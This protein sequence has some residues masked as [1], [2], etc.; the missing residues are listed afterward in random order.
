MFLYLDLTSGLCRAVLPMFLVS[1]IAYRLASLLIM[2]MCLNSCS[3]K[4]KF[5]GPL[6]QLVIMLFT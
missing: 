3:E 5:Q 2:D 1:P 6:S 4:R